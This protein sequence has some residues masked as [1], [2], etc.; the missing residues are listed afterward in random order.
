[1]AAGAKIPHARDQGLAADALAKPEAKGRPWMP[2][3]GGCVQVL[4]S[5]ASPRVR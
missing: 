2:T 4:D 3:R 1:M 5:A